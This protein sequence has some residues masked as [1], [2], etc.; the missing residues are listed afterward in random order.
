MSA[1]QKTYLLT[2]ELTVEEVNTLLQGLQ[3]LPAKTS[4]PLTN[5][6]VKMAQEQLPKEEEAK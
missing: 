5:K 4:N 2:L 3:E 1:D 6:I